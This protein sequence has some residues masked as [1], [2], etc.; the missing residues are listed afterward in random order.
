MDHFPGVQWVIAIYNRYASLLDPATGKEGLKY[1]SMDASI[2]KLAA[3]EAGLKAM[4][5]S[6]VAPLTSPLAI[7]SQWG[8]L[9]SVFRRMK[10]TQV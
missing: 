5:N 8:L 10:N 1:G 4:Q 9:Y 2:Q 6:T 3:W 7:R